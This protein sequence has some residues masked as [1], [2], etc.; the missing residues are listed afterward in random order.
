[1]SGTGSR[2]DRGCGTERSAEAARKRASAAKHQA[3]QSQQHDAYT[4]SEQGRVRRCAGQA[5]R[6]A[7]ISLMCCWKRDQRWVACRLNR[8]IPFKPE[9]LIALLCFIHQADDWI[10]ALLRPKG[11]WAGPAPGPDEPQVYFET[12]GQTP[13]G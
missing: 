13:F 10:L 1:M 4:A 8:R 6:G 7:E 5:R 3:G 11:R 9:G 2:N 12:L